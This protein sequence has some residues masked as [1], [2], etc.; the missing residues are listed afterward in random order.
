VPLPRL[1][2]GAGSIG[3]AS[4]GDDNNG[5]PLT[6][7]STLARMDVDPW[8]EASKLTRLPQGRTER[9]FAAPLPNEA[10]GNRQHARG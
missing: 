3:H 10:R 4:V 5:M 7:L 1:A 2:W 6:A 9:Q 8:E